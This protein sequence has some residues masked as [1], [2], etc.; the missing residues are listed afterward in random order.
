VKLKLKS[1]RAELTCSSPNVYGKFS[2]CRVLL[3]PPYNHVL[4]PPPCLQKGLPPPL[5]SLLLSL[6]QT[7]LKLLLP[8]L[9]LVLILVLVLVLH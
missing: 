9:V 4:F 6:K 1:T 7:Q 3:F 5:L 8:L 2:D